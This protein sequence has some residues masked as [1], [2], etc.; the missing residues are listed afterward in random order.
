MHIVTV[1]DYDGSLLAG[2]RPK[3]AR[4]LMKTKRARPVTYNGAFAI[5]LIRKRAHKEEVR[6]NTCDVNNTTLINGGNDQ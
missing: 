4:K 2:C 3:R 1:L 5:Q 6:L